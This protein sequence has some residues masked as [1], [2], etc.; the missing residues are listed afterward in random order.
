MNRLFIL[1]LTLVSLL[2]AFATDNGCTHDE[3]LVN[4][5]FGDPQCRRVT[6]HMRCPGGDENKYFN[7]VCLRW[8]I[9]WICSATSTAIDRN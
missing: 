4:D 1:L 9:S 3:E 8:F 2:P 5:E 6:V 7:T